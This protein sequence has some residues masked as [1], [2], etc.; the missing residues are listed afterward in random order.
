MKRLLIAAAETDRNGRNRM[1]Q[2][3]ACPEILALKHE[4]RIHGH[5]SNH[6]CGFSMMEQV[7]LCVV[8]T[9]GELTWRLYEPQTGLDECPRILLS[10]FRKRMS[11]EAATA[12]RILHK[13]RDKGRK[14][15]SARRKWNERQSVV[16]PPSPPSPR[17]GTN[18]PGKKVKSHSEEANLVPFNGKF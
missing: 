13:L 8:W 6:V 10:S 16:V 1:A 11:A 2:V 15:G 12:E 3:C 14:E 7:G 9:T 4:S 17:H 5:S 18:L